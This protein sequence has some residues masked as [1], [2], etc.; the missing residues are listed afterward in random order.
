MPLREPALPPRITLDRIV[1]A[2]FE[3]SERAKWRLLRTFPHLV[4]FRS[5]DDLTSEEEIWCQVQGAIDD[6]LRRCEGCL[7]IG[8]GAFC[9]DC[10]RPFSGSAHECRECHAY[11]SGKF[12]SSCG[13]RRVN[14]MWEAM[15][16]G[17]LTM[18]DLDELTSR[19]EISAVDV[20]FLENALKAP[21]EVAHE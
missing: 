10:G 8:H 18:A 21:F 12:C 2:C 3:P 9:G 1:E 15:Q 14:E 5:L 7:A 19:E 16:N 13:T 17:T 6:G 11:V 4:P 20:E